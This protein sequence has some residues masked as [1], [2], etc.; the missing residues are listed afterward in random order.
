[1]HASQLTNLGPLIAASAAWA[2]DPAHSFWLANDRGRMTLATTL[3]A[4]L[5]ADLVKVDQL[6]PQT[7]TVLEARGAALTVPLVEM[8]WPSGRHQLLLPVRWETDGAPYAGRPY[9]LGRF[10]CYSLVRDWMV[11]ER[12][13]TMAPLTDSP[14]RLANQMLTD[15]AFVTNPEIERWERV[16]VPQ[17]GD[18]ILFAMTQ[19]DGHTPGAAN[20]AGVFLGDGRFLHHFANRLSCQADLDAVWKARVAAFMRWR[21]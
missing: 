15:G 16:A 12:G 9:Q 18:G 8:E 2:E 5:F 17:P 7:D 19:D 11:R 21:G 20:H 14:A 10:D 13:I 3:P 1:M 4:R 6:T